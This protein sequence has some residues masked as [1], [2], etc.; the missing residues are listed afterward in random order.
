M[1][2]TATGGIIVSGRR[3]GGRDADVEPRVSIVTLGVGDLGRAVAFYRD[4][5][6]W[7]LSGASE[8]DIAFFKTGGVVLALY[9]REALAEDVGVDPA[10]GGFSGVTLAHNVAQKER[11]D[12]TLAEAASAGA[13][14]VKGAQEVFWGGRSGCFAD[15]DGH[16]WEVAWAPG[17]LS[18]RTAASCYP[19]RLPHQEPDI[20]RGSWRGMLRSPRII[21]VV[22]TKWGRGGP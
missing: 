13:R 22:P 12:S 7:P 5:L 17:F 3:T 1:K 11:V 15:R 19:T 2:A 10:G 14:I 9:P 16:L 8:E 20:T 18:P 6:G 21:E 4:G